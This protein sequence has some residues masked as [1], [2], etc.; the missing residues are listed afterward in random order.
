ML[1]IGAAERGSR[2]SQGFLMCRCDRVRAA[3]HAPRDPS[4]VLERLNGLAEI[5]KCGV[6]VLLE[7]FPVSPP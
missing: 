1:Q 4:H 7:S 2:V 5:V 3:E 6:D